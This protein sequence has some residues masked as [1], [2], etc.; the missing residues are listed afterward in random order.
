M[1]ER[2][3]GMDPL[4]DEL[5]PGLVGLDRNGGR[6][7]R[8]ATPGG[9]SVIELV[10]GRCSGRTSL[11]AALS[12]DYAPLVPLVRADLAVPGF[13]DPFLAGLPDARPDGSH[14]TD[15]LYLLSYKLGLRVRRTMQ[16]L[17]FPRLSLGLLVVTAW[18]ADETS[19]AATT[20]S[21][22]DLRR[23]EQRLRDVISRNGDGQGERRARLAS[24]SR[25]SNGTFPPG[26]PD[27]DRWRARAGPHSGPPRPACCRPR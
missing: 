16:R 5:V 19:A 13:G 8:V 1:G 14:L 20:V 3:Y 12:A 10:G 15:L 7:P 23:A 18:R 9:T 22:Q 6:R 27:S 4:F 11:L 25:P 24:G 2:L 17:R 21:P 26:R